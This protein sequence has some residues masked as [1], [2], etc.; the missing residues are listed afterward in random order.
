MPGP[1]QA[2]YEPQGPRYQSCNEGLDS[3]IPTKHNRDYTRLKNTDGITGRHGEPDAVARFRNNPFLDESESDRRRSWHDAKPGAKNVPL[4]FPNRATIAKRSEMDEDL[5]NLFRKI[6]KYAKFLKEL[7][8]HKRRRIKGDVE[9]GGVV[10]SLVLHEDTRVW[11]QRILP[12]KCPDPGIFVVPCIIGKKTFTNAMLDLGALINVM[13]ASIYKSLNLGDL[14]PT[15]ME[16]QLANRSVVQPLGVLEDVKELIFPA[17]FYVLDVEDDVF[18]GG[19]ALILGRPFFMTAKTKIDVHVGT[20]SMEF[21]DIYIEFNIFEA[22]KHLAKD[23]STFSL[24]AIDGLM[25]E[26]FRLG[27]GI[28]SLVGFVDKIDSQPTDSTNPKYVSLQPQASNLKPLPKLLKY[29][30][31]RVNQQFL[32]IIV[33][34]LHRDQEEKFLEVFKKHKKAIGWMLADLL[35]I[36][37]S[38]YKTTCSWDHLSHLG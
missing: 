17:N 33:N 4:P 30:Y 31:L 6:P 10:S 37:P 12:K 21:E 20:F 19:S 34:N 26:Y 28:T 23:H 14:E 24:D 11:I 29:A 1:S 15:G 22:L 9:T 16:V 7:C 35:E 5:L 13:P 25:E 18:E 27:I 8:V 32:V 38:I 2:N 36:N 3:T